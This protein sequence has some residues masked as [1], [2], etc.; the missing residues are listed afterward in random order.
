MKK[1]SKIGLLVLAFAVI[2]AG[3]VMSV[4]GAEQQDGKV[5]YV[6]AATNETMEGTLAEAWENAADGTVIT[7]LGNC[8]MEEKLVLNGKNLTVDIANYTLISTD[9][10]AFELKRDTSLTIIGSG[11]IVLDGRL[12]TSS[13]ENVTF[14]IEGTAGTKG[15]DI[16]HNGCADNRI[17]YTEYGNW[18]FKN[19]DVCSTA[20]GKDWHCFFEMRNVVAT[21]VNFVF[22]TVAFEYATPYVSH[23]GQF[24][25]N[26]AGTGHLEIKNSSFKTE[27]SGIKSGVVDNLNEEVILIENSLISCVTDA[28][29]LKAL[30]GTGVAVIEKDLGRRNYAILGMNDSWGGSPKGIV[31]V[32]DS[33][34]ES[35]YRTVCYENETDVNNSVINYT[36]TTVRVIGLNGN[37]DSENVN[38]AIMVNTYGNTVF[39]NIKESTVGTAKNYSASNEDHQITKKPFVVAD[40]GFRTNIRGITTSKKD[41]TGIRVI[42]KIIDVKDEKGEVI[43]EKYEY[44]YSSESEIYTWVY[45][46]IGNPD[47]P[48]LLVKKENAVGYADAYKF[49][50]FDTYRFA[51][52]TDTVYDEYLL[53]KDHKSYKGTKSK[54]TVNGKEVT[55]LTKEGWFAYE[56]FGQ[57]NG[58]GNPDSGDADNKSKNKMENFQ[59]AQRGGTYL[60]AGDD[61]NKYM[62]Y[63]VEPDASNPDAERV[64]LATVEGKEKETPF[65]IFG[66]MSPSSENDFKYVRTMVKGE[67]R[68]SVMVIDIDFGSEN[69][70]YPDLN[71]QFTSRCNGKDG[72][73]TLC[74]ADA[75]MEIRNGGTVKNNLGTTGT[76]LDS[77]PT[78]VLN[79]A[80][81]WNHFSIV[82]YTDSEYQGGLA[83][84]YLNGELM[85]T[86]KFYD[87]TKANDTVYLQGLRFNI[88]NEQ[89]ANSILCI[90]NISLRCYTNYQ[91]EGEKDGGAKSPEYYITK[92]VEKNGETVREF[93]TSP[94]RYINSYLTVV[95]NSYRG[96]DIDTLQEKATELG[97]VIRLQEDFAGVIKENATIYTNGY[98]LNPIGDSH[99]ANVTYDANTGNSFYQFNEIYNN[100]NVKYYWYIGE[101]GNVEHMKD[102]N[103]PEYYLVTTVLPGQTPEYSGPEISNIKDY[104]KAAIKVHCGWHSAGDDFTVETFVPLTLSVAI[105]Q[106]DTP[107]FVYPSYRLVDPTA[108]VKDASGLIVDVAETAYDASEMFTKLD[109]GQTFVVCKDFQFD[110]SKIGHIF[111]KASAEDVV[112]YGAG[113]K[114]SNSTEHKVIPYTNAQLAAMREASAKIALD[115]NGHTIKVGHATKRGSLVSVSSNVTFS[116]Y[117]SQ[118]GGMIY[119]VQGS[120]KDT[121]IG[122]FGNR[123]IDMYYRSE[124]G[125]SSFDTTNSHLVVGTVEV[126]G[127]VIPGSNLT[128]YGGVLV[129]ART[130]DDSCTVEVDGIRAIRHTPDSA[131]AFMSRF[132]SGKYSVTNTTIIAPTSSTVI[133]IK[134]DLKNNEGFTMT[135]EV[136]F[137]N[138]LILNNGTSNILEHTGDDE[139]NVC[140]TLRN[141]I[142]NGKISTSSG[143]GK[144]R[145]EGGVFASDI[146]AAGTNV[147]TYADGISQAKYNVPLTLGS[148]TD[149]GIFEIYVPE[150]IYDEVGNQTNVI[151]YEARR[152]VYVEAGKEHLV[153]EGENVEVIVLGNIAVGTGTEQDMC[154]ITFNGLDGKAIKSEK[155][156]KGGI[157]TAPDV[158][159]YK[160]SDFITLV[161]NGEFDSEILPAEKT[162]IFNPKYEIVSSVEGIKSSVSFYTNFN[163]NIYVPNEYKEYFRKANVNGVQLALTD[164]EVNGV[165][166]VMC[167]LPVNANDF[168]DS[169]TFELEFGEMVDFVPYSAITDVTTSVLEYAQTI[170]SDTDGEYTEADKTLVYAAL[171]YAN[172]T[173]VFADGEVN[174]EVKAL[175]TQYAELAESDPEDKYSEAVE[176]TNLSTA[177]IKASVRLGSAPAFVFTV[178]RDFVGTVKFTIGEVEK[179]YTVEANDQRTIIIKDLTVAEFTSDINVTVDGKIGDDSVVITNGV[180][181]LATYAKYHI[182]N[183]TYG[184]NEIPTDSQLASEK[185]LAVIN[186]VYAYAAAAKAYMAQ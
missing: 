39:L 56:P 5:S 161:Y 69:G 62:K 181:N 31:N 125:S 17:V 98:T 100:L 130:G 8:E 19:I 12:A 133:S 184:N 6:Y 46:P 105:S 93:V 38:R 35:N 142:T 52:V 117:S 72:Y 140:L 182:A 138:C 29:S 20:Q 180:Y 77:V 37:D 169:V 145:V 22:D 27:H 64:T 116:I 58:N 43:G 15:I 2:C 88:P 78:P 92:E 28:V 94:S 166:Y 157:P 90:D 26:V 99:S 173:I 154:M 118:P 33:F 126:D 9:V 134:D 42:E 111:R 101:W 106:K 86:Q 114:T 18:S 4:S 132:F 179:E 104:D 32:K 165:Q 41:D 65:W 57:T 135:P 141:I 113:V 128:L 10:A 159:D 107:V 87:E 59:W 144:L 172:N 48:Y 155:F 82:F 91:A 49:A 164:V 45:D 121:E 127:N 175:V 75:W 70:V 124:Y 66:E 158:P 85:G 167:T 177:F 21:D 71:I 30:N 50:G 122:V 152:L 147:M 178:Q 170:L 143:R 74:Q 80:N 96:A 95:G 112:K 109:A 16:D 63:W 44:A 102:I 60:I 168:A 115:L 34:L 40:E 146:Q 55:E 51:Y 129:E 1:L 151:N 185:A 108:Y 183:S 176:Q 137:D 67:N 7:L 149:S 81:E 153:P 136:I 150:E 54:V 25:T 61:Q 68:K 53:Y 156:I 123:I 174:E 186:S 148:I 79:G 103:N 139:S 84:V 11:T 14:S 171:V 110:D 24:V 89:I 73:A 76:D 97:S 160:V 131:G 83:Y 23:P 47:A 36:D 120:I 119:S 13:V 162:T 3:I 163:I